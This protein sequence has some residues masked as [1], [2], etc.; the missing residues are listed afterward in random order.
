MDSKIKGTRMVTN[1]TP[2]GLFVRHAQLQP[3]R[4]ITCIFDVIKELRGC[5]DKFVS[6]YLHLFLMLSS[7]VLLNG[8][9]L[10]TASRNICN[11]GAGGVF[12]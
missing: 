4:G 6:E 7:C 12:A 1:S 9:I 5:I 2:R 10:T 8:F 3:R 11:T